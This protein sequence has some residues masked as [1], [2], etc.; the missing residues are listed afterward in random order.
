[1]F[2]VIANSAQAA[3][4]PYVGTHPVGQRLAVNV[5]NGAAFVSLRGIQPSE[6]LVLVNR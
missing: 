5:R 4:V 6:V 1:M 3:T 2:S